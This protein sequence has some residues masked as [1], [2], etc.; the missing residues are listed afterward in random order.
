MLGSGRVSK[1]KPS[2][3]L[4]SKAGEW[5]EVTEDFLFSTTREFE[6]WNFFT[7]TWSVLEQSMCKE[8]SITHSRFEINFLGRPLIHLNLFPQNARLQLTLYLLI[9]SCQCSFRW[10]VF[11]WFTSPTVHRYDSLCLFHFKKM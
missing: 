2:H 11:T 7:H 6:W 9:K 10:L 4:D 1:K 3:F 8:T 5:S